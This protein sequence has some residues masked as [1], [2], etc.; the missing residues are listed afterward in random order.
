MGI[1]TR[2]KG[3]RTQLKA[4]RFATSFPDTT[5]LIMHQAS[6]WATPQPFDL[7]L[8]RPTHW[9]R[10]VEVRAN[11]WGVARPQTRALAALPGEEYMR[12]IWC[13]KDRCQVPQIRQ[14]DGKEWVHQDNPWEGGE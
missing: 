8:F 13:F 11:Q 7:I 2:K 6:H 9:I 14:W 5:C 1:Q 12:Q 10:L 4:F 3:Q